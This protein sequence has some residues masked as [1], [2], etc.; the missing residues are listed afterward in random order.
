MR[1]SKI[2]LGL[3]IN[4]I[5]FAGVDACFADV[6]TQFQQAAAYR[7]DGYFDKAE[8]LYK[9]VITENP[10]TNNALK[11]QKELVLLSLRMQ[12]HVQSTINDQAVLGK[13]IAD[14]SANS[15][16]PAALYEI[17]DEYGKVRRHEKAKSLYQQIIQ[18][19][20]GSVYA[21]KAR[22]GIP[23]TDI[24]ALIEVKSDQAAKA[25]IEKFISDYSN[26]PH[27]AES[28]H[29]IA[30]QWR[31]SKNFA[32]AIRTYQYVV[33]HWP[34]AEYGM[35]SQMGVAKA[36]V[37][38]GN[39]DA[40]K[41]ALSKLIQN[42][43]GNSGLPEA[44]ERIAIQYRK[45]SKFAE[46]KALYQKIVQIDPNSSFGGRAKVKAVEMNILSDVAAG[47]DTAV[48]AAVDNL[49]ANFAGNQA[50]AD[51]LRD[52][53]WEYDEELG[54]YQQAKA[55]YQKII[56]RYP[57]NYRASKALIEITKGQI[58]ELVKAGQDDKVL[59]EIDK[60]VATYPNHAFLPDTLCQI[61]SNYYKKASQPDSN[62]PN[63]IYFR[64][65]AE[66]YE[67][68]INELPA[69]RSFLPR[70]CCYAGDCYRELGEYENA[71]KSYQKVIDTY[72][73]CDMAW[74]ALFMVGQTY[75]Q[76]GKLG[77]IQKS[78]ADAQTKA[79]F[80]QLLAKYPDCKV[81]AIAQNWLSSQ[82]K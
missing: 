8:E 52:V 50:V 46:A 29:D 27:I 64:K 68:V 76:I 60:L 75:Q 9:K 24:R 78:E 21:A 72:P 82:V 28:L 13:L 65:A 25:A 69:S 47:K 79:A 43:S 4:V 48:S 12:Y 57:D 71:I 59:P 34:T 40:V 70:A 42:Y 32:E 51:A 56:D 39:F 15:N 73:T 31:W 6:L 2:F 16:L 49:L 35:W 66:I 77:I 10:G 81:A 58:L 38:S 37:E 23:K 53:A 17:A 74:N 63:I 62:Q 54:K 20:L 22:L 36:N 7:D 61:A 45:A 14:F 26:S 5:I 3:V 41:P 30:F 80:E 19:Y 11:A 18:Q 1:K 55:I 44:L 67:K 33:D